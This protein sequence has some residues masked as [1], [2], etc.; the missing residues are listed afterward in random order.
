MIKNSNEPELKVNEMQVDKP[1]KPDL[2]DLYRL[3]FLLFTIKEQL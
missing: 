2:K 1:Y 3:Y